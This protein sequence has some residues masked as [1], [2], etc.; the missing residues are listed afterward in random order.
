MPVLCWILA[1][2]AAVGLALWLLCGWLFCR[3]MGR[4]ATD[5]D[6]FCKNLEQGP[7]KEYAEIIRAGRDWYHAQ[8]T[9]TWRIDGWDGTPLVASYLPPE[10]TPRATFILCHG[11]R[12]TAAG[13]F[14]GI[15]GEY[16]RR[17]FGVLLPDQRAQGRSGG[18]FMGMGVLES[19]DLLCWTQEVN[20]RLGHGR[21]ILYGGMS[22]GAATVQ[23][24]CGQALPENVAGLVA[25]CGFSSPWEICG[26]VLRKGAHLPPF[27]LLYLTN[28]WC[29]RLAH[30]DLRGCSAP[31]IMGESRLPVLWI[32]GENDGFVPCDMSRRAFAASHAKKWLV[33]VPGASHGMSFLVDPARCTQALDAF[34]T[35]SLS[36]T[37]AGADTGESADF[38]GA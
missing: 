6:A 7:L 32:H 5:E 25:D 18:R 38:A 12:S 14:S 21:P 35:E 26:A 1:V 2:V 9:E 27:P 10:G 8:C 13:D 30:Y 36:G 34:L 16:H 22:M 19:R 20:A 23:F 29:R 37:K 11:Y 4:R 17:G 24:A 28:F 3:L 33:T 31:E 15:L